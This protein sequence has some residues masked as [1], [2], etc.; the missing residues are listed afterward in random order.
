[1]NLLEYLA[2]AAALLPALYIWCK[3]LGVCAIL[4]AFVVPGYIY[5]WAG[6]EIVTY[7]W[8]WALPL[9]AG[10]IVLIPTYR[11]VYIRVSRCVNGWSKLTMEVE[12][13][14]GHVHYIKRIDDQTYINGGSGSGK[15]ESCNMAFVRHAVRF[16]MSMLLHDLKKYE[17]TQAVYPLFAEAGIPYHVFALFDYER[18]VR[19]N[20]IAPMYIEDE[21]SLKSR[22][23][24][25]LI[26]AQGG[27][28]RDSTSTGGFFKNTA[29]SLLESITWYLKLYKPECCHL[30]FL[31]SIINDPDNLHL[32]EG[33]KVIPF[34][35]LKK[36]LGCD[37]QV[38]S[39][40]S[41]F[42]QGADNAETTSNILQ[43]VILALNTI[44]T[45]AG[46]FLLSG[47]D[48]DLRINRPGNCEALALVN[49]PKNS[50]SNAPILAM[51]A[52]AGLLMMGDQD[53]DYAVALLDEAA[54]LPSP[55]VQNYMAYLRSLH[56]CVV[57]TTQ[58]LSQIQRTQ[59]GKEFNQ[60]TVLSNLAHQFFGRTRTEQTAKYYEGLM[61]RIVKTEKSYS[62]SSN[63]TTVTS[64]GVKQP[65][66]IASDFYLLKKGE[67]VYFYG[68]VKRFRF[69]HIIGKK[70]LPPKIRSMDRAALHEIA[71]RIRR[72]A[73]EFMQSF[74]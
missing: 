65:R 50:S 60:R 64:R 13:S 30:P 43:T 58:D 27:D 39:M 67:F 49:E 28:A 73:N 44:N 36:M 10:L 22:I 35:R 34:G 15:T 68:D 41:V 31:M 9:A 8:S 25:F 45:D 48:I 4:L 70:E 47:N 2:I 71:V 3:P 14:R 33:K 38:S 18:C 69:K 7:L 51:I 32:K 6:L 37:P 55:R 52:D 57:Y 56:V 24:S 66:Y 23:D 29:A 11:W 53:N 1:M 54:E 19:I 5:V 61:P 63:G 12:D 59:G 20:P 46:F 62:S 16:R 17:L 26:A 40:A 21:Q 72:E 42:F 74:N